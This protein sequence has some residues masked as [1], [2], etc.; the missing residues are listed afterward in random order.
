M[1]KQTTQSERMR[2]RIMQWLSGG[3]ATYVAMLGLSVVGVEPTP[4]NV[5]IIVPVIMAIA[6]MVVSRLGK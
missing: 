6:G 5:A 4:E 1:K 2:P 3:G